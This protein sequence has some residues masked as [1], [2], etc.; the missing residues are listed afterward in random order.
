MAT[1]KSLEQLFVEELK[2][3]YDAEKRLTKAL[4]KVARNAS[5]DELRQAIENHLEETR[6][7]VERLEQAFAMLER[8]ARG[9]PCE[10]MKGLISEAEELM[11]E[12]FDDGALLDAGLIAGCQKVEH[13]EIATYGTLKTWAHVLGYEEIAELLEQTLEEEK[14]A[15]EKLTEVAASINVKNPFGE[16]A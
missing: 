5:S 7:Q 14:A 9:K 8:N 2:D 3:I 11:D 13:Y 1:I 6:G 16:A 10:A 12:E 4:P 15:D